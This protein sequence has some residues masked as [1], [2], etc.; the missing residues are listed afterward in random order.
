M[1]SCSA[2]VSQIFFRFEAMGWGESAGFAEHLSAAL[3]RPID[4]IL[5]NS[6]ASFATREILSN[7]LARGR[8]R[9]AGKK[10]VIWEFAARELS[11]GNWKLLDLKL[12]EAKPSRFLSLKA[13]EEIEVSGTVESFSP[14]PRPGTVPYKDHIEALHLVDI[15][16]AD[17]R[18]EAESHAQAVVYL[19]SMRDNVWTSAARL[20][21]GDRVKLRLR[22][23]PDVSAQYE[24]FNRTELDDSALQLEEPV[25]GEDIELLKR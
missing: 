6:D 4:C 13:G 11:F 17:S 14:V 3:R 12:G 23:W 18:G 21:P 22:P 2:I 24:K 7:E 16:A 1:C 15:V 5:R 19:W 8:D 10:L 20:R 25:W 9:L